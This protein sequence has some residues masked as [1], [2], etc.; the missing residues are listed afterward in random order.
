MVDVDEVKKFAGPGS[1]LAVRKLVRKWGKLALAH[2]TYP[3]LY[4]MA[5][6]AKVDWNYETWTQQIHIYLARK[7]I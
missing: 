4:F 3:Y 7:H 6:V 5:N 1:K 2:V